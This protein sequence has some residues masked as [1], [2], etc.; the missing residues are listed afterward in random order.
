MP[1]LEWSYGYPTAIGT[2]V[3]ACGLLYWRFRKAGWL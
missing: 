3:A 1:E 2:I